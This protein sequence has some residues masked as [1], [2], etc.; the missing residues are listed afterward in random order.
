MSDVPPSLAAGWREGGRG[1]TSCCLAVGTV[2]PAAVGEA[3][4][5][6]LYLRRG[7]RAAVTL[8]HESALILAGAGSGKTRVITH[9][10]GRLIQAGLQ[11][12][13]V[14]A[15]TFTNKAAAEMQALVNWMWYTRCVWVH[16]LMCDGVRVCDG[17]C[18]CCWLACLSACGLVLLCA[19]CAVLAV[20][21][22]ERTVPQENK[23]R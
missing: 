16:V 5:K 12:E 11:P 15:I 7:Q 2:T 22:G 6:R 19:L 20:S 21:R 9:K 18:F 13:Q 4:H 1:G 8:P 17:V 14:A 23:S 3:L 10:I